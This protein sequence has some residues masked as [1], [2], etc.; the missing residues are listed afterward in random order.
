MANNVANVDDVTDAISGVAVGDRAPRK[1]HRLPTLHT[2]PT[3]MIRSHLHRVPEVAA[4]MTATAVSYTHL[5]LPTIL[6]V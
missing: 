2:M 5:T 4:E 1:A 6:R 3:N